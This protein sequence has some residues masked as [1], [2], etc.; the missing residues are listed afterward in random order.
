MIERFL[1]WWGRSLLACIPTP[2]LRLFQPRMR[3]IEWPDTDRTDV[4]LRRRPRREPKLPLHVVLPDTLAPS[5]RLAL[6][7]AAKADVES[8]V[9]LQLG[10]LTPF[11]P[12]QLH[13]AASPVEADSPEGRFLVD[14]SVVPKSIVLNVAESVG[15]AGHKLGKITART[16]GAV[17]WKR[18]HPRLAYFPAI[19]FLGIAIGTFVAAALIQTGRLDQYLE[20]LEQRAMLERKQALRSQ[21][22]RREYEQALRTAEAIRA[23][24]T[25]FG[26]RLA[27]LEE[28]ARRTDDSVWF[29][30]LEMEGNELKLSGI[31]SGTAS[32]IPMLERSPKLTNVKAT[33][34][35]VADARL[36]GDR[37]E[38]RADIVGAVR[39]GRPSQ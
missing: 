20:R 21:T 17:L 13:L 31:N 24:E 23:A 37:F 4:A 9:R 18:R 2:L 6:P 27:V 16:T 38:V 7:L 34:A 3:R 11:S 39:S 22:L 29:L 19:V 36:G 35:T 15:K 33:S 25:Q 8:A 28:V 26:S 32:P 14:L 5:R 30:L 12:E 10:Q 1:S